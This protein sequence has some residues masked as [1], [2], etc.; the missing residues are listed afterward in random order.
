MID[1]SEQVMKAI[2]DWYSSVYPHGVRLTCQQRESLGR[3]IIQRARIEE[4]RPVKVCL[5]CA[6]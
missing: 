6:K 3:Y 2:E 1:Q 4:G 5:D